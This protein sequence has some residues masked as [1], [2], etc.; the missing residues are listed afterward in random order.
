MS[1]QETAHITLSRVETPQMAFELLGLGTAPSKHDTYEET[2]HVVA[3][4]KA[5]PL[6]RC[7]GRYRLPVARQDFSSIGRLLVLPAATPLEIRSPH[8]PERV[9][10]CLFSDDILKAHGEN[11]D[12]Y[13][14]NVLSSCLDLRHKGIVDTLGLLGEELR[15]PGLASAAM[16]EALGITLMIQFTRFISN[17]A[18]SEPI[19]RGGLSRRHLRLITEA[20]E[21]E[22]KS[23]SLSDLSRISGLSVRHLT[24]AFKQT[25]G[26][27]LFNYVE[28]VRL[29]KAKALLADTDLLMK[30]IA[31]R[32]GFSC[33]SSLSVAFRNL[34]GESPQSYRKRARPRGGN[35]APP[36]PFAPVASDH[37][38]RA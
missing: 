17:H 11:C 7:E 36:A 28:Q 15:A 9:V 6:G 19:H 3:L 29:N 20:V 5:P 4:Q 30:E 25:T 13:D 35:R 18:R 34:A 16:I 32:L 8:R 37:P 1:V 38:N 21:G 31:H 14:R 26:V 10:R 33:A 12:L 22:L 23:P 2:L 24:R 27:T